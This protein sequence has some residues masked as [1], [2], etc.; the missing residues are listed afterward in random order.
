[1]GRK[2][3]GD[4]KNRSHP[5][6]PYG[7]IKKIYSLKREEI[8]GRLKEFK[9]LWFKRD[10]ALFEELAFCIL[11]PQSKAK[12]CA[13]ALE[14]LKKKGL[15]FKGSAREVTE[16]IR[17]VRFKNKKA[18]Y[19][20]R[21]RDIFCRD[22]KVCIKPILSKFKEPHECREWLV[23]HITGLG[24]KEASHFLRNI[25]RGETIAILDRH[26]L[27]NLKGF[28]IIEEIPESLTRSRYREIERKM[29]AFSR[30]I[31]IP[32]SH[33]DLLFWYK[34]TGDIFK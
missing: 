32:L 3:I 23:K 7:L 4:S 14:R 2:C 27:R 11:T 6:N 5:N 22:E 10:E 15:L 29:E 20:L 24:Y 30:R 33:L 34:E 21:A 13:A 1:M 25:G 19:L 26:I 18:L 12:V 16:V 9:R 28:R 17:D 8:H 31:K